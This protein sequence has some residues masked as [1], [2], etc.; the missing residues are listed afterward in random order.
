MLDYFLIGIESGIARAYNAHY[1]SFCDHRCDLGGFGSQKMVASAHDDETEQ[2]GAD[3]TEPGTHLEFINQVS[4]SE[5][6]L[7]CSPP[8][9]VTVQG[10][11]KLGK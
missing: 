11:R 4:G 3:G 5:E 1:D 7:W 2:V 10:V 8:L 9:T 6:I